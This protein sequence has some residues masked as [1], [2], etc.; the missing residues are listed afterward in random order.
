MEPYI[1]EIRLMSFPVVPQGWVP[2]DGRLLSISNN[3]ALFSL[4]G[5]YYGGDGMRSFGVPDLRGRM[6]VHVGDRYQLGQQGGTESYTL[7]SSEM[8]A[9]SHALQGSS[10]SA[11]TAAPANAVT[12]AK[13]RLGRDIMGPADS[14]M[15][16][17]AVA[18]AGGSQ[19]HDNMP[20]FLVLNFM[21]A[22]TGV[23]PSRN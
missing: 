12:G 6:P 1:G 5:T 3:E 11:V 20:P 19:P 8:P 15:H 2:C 21:I 7:Q 16:Y 9:H 4:L 14:A 23:Y 17:A 18:I 22:A 13:G 10:Q